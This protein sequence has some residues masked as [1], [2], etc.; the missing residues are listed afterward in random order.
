LDQTGRVESTSPVS[1]ATVRLTVGPAGVTDP[2][3]ADAVISLPV[4]DAGQTD[5]SSVE[6]IWRT[7]CHRSYFFP[8][9]AEAGE[10]ADGQDSVEIASL[11]EGCVLA[12]EVAE[13]FTA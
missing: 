1:S 7:F 8:S 2:S 13:A 5:T 10:W 4:V 6:A 9:R 12:R 3:P 11:D